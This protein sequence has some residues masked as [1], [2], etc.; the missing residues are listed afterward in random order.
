MADRA[1]A[2]GEHVEG[3]DLGAVRQDGEIV[4]RI[5]AVEI[6]VE[7]EV[8]PAALLFPGDQAL[9]RRARDDGER[10]LLRDVGRIALPGAEDIGAHRA[11]VRPLRPEHVGVNGKG[12]LVAE[13]SGEI[14]RAILT[15]KA[16]VADDRTARRQRPALRRDALDMTAQFDLLGEQRPARGAILSAFVGDS[17]RVV[18]G[19]LSRRFESL[20]LVIHAIDLHCLIEGRRSALARPGSFTASPR[21][22]RTSPLA[23]RGRSRSSCRPG[24]A[25]VR[26]RP[27]RPPT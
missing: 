23:D 4:A 26:A 17:H 27:C 10:D 16:I 18:A 21:R 7:A 11:G 5:G 8:A 22:A 19:E 25:P 20:G 1:V 3:R 24:P 12:L 14:R 6:A 15:L 9:D 13:Q 2:A